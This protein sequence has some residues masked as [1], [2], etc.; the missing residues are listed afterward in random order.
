MF[1]PED[2]NRVDANLLERG[3]HLFEDDL[4]PTEIIGDNT[5][6]Q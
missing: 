2:M 4:M 1:L 5:S 6:E 3:K